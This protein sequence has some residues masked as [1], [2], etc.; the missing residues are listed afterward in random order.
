MHL[1]ISCR[2]YKEYTMEKSILQL[3]KESLNELSSLP[4]LKSKPKKKEDS[5][6]KEPTSTKEPKRKPLIGAKTKDRIK[7][8][9]K[10]V[11][12]TAGD[13]VKDELKDISVGWVKK[14]AGKLK[15]KN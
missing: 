4:H 5:S 3:S 7:Q 14:I 15:P 9:A 11:L 1:K 8:H 12:T 10:A 13:A 2:N 6:T